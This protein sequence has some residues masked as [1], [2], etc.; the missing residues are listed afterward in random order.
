M[1]SSPKLQKTQQSSL[2]TFPRKDK[3]HENWALNDVGTCYFILGKSYADQKQWKEAKTSFKKVLKEFYFSQSW[4]NKGWFWKVSTAARK[5][6]G[7]IG[8]KR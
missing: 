4:D 1:L 8:S 5:E 3:A 2:V 7:K 6:L